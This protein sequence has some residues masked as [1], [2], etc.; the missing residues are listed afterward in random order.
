LTPI[1]PGFWFVSDHGRP[2]A[3]GA[4]DRRRDRSGARA[5]PRTPAGLFSRVRGSFCLSRFRQ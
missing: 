4:A 1:A 5:P 2:H 3:V